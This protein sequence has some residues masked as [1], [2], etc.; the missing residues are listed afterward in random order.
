MKTLCNLC[1]AADLPKPISIK[2]SKTGLKHISMSEYLVYT[3]SHVII[4]DYHLSVGM[5]KDENHM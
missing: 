5:I 1:S 2:N 3:A 4:I